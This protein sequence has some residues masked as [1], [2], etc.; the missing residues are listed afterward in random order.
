MASKNRQTEQVKTPLYKR[1]WF[2]ILIAF[3][4]LGGCVRNCTNSRG[5]NKEQVEPAAAAEET[6]SP[7]DNKVKAEKETVA[8]EKDES[9]QE[10][11]AEVE[12][13]EVAL[14]IDLVAGK[15]NE[16]SKSRTWNAGTEYEETQLV[17]YVPAGTYEV[18]NAGE[19]PTQVNVYEGVAVTDEGWE[20]PANVGDVI[21][22]KVGETGQI[23]VPEG[24]Y[25][26]IAEPTHVVL[27]MK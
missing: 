26:D 18:T 14:T 8:S 1:K 7:E 20:E 21:T 15:E 17:Y 10:T 16:Y 3:L 11:E 5:D 27:E 4:L 12:P 23:T 9:S 22:L 19:Y 2:I 25:V 6:A 24:Y 13:E